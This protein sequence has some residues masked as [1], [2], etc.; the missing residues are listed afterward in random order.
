VCLSKEEWCICF[1]RNARHPN[2]YFI[3]PKVGSQMMCHNL[4]KLWHISQNDRSDEI[5]TYHLGINFW[6]KN[7]G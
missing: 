3:F 7:L 1:L 4:M 2:F 5:V 6:V